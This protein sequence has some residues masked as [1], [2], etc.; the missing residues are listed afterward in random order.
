MNGMNVEW[1]GSTDRGERGSGGENEEAKGSAT[2][3]EPKKASTKKANAVIRSVHLMWYG[4][5][6]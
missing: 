5:A 4:M 3:P 1:L 6:H 2:E